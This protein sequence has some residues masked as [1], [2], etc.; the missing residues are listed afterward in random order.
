MKYGERLKLARNHAKLTQAELAE[1][2]G[3]LCS[4][5]NISGLEKSETATGSEFS[6]QFALACGVDPRWLATGEGQMLDGII[7]HDQRQKHLFS[8]CESLPAYAVDE[9]VR[10]GD[11]LV[12]LIRK[13]E[14]S[15]TKH[16]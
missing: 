13:A 9:L 8:V 14:E 15:Q 16:G 5:P 10:Y 1:R 12:E 7:V 2:I 4:Q 11:S 6:V 3:N